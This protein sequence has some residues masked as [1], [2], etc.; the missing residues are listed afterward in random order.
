[1]LVVTDHLNGIPLLH[2][3]GEVDHG[4]APWLTEAVQKAFLEQPSCILLDLESCPYMDSGGVGV[5]LDTLRKVRNEGW[6]GVIAP[7]PDVL[8]ILTLV[9]LTLDPAFHEFANADEA[10][11]HIAA[12]GA[13][14]SAASAS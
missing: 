14:R 3:L 9:G 7:H 2:I 11:R 10:G 13:A 4:S 12:W 1:M 8:R 5:L 6:L